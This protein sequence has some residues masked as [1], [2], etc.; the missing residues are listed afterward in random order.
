MSRFRRFP[1]PALMLA[2]SAA[3]LAGCAVG[4]DYQQPR[5]ALTPT[6]HAAAP[7]AAT[8]APA[9]ETWWNGFGD[10]ALTRVIQRAAAQNMDI[11]QA[12]ARIAQ[13]R[14]AVRA[15]NAALLPHGE[16]QGGATDVSQS[17][18]SPFGEIGKQVPGFERDYGLYE[19][20]AA[21]S[22]EIDLFGGLRRQRE[23]ARADD[24]ATL[25]QAE[26]VQVSVLAEA[27][28][29][30]LQV[31]G[32]Q[33]RLAVAQRQIG[34]Q[35]DLVA[36]LKH[37]VDDGVGSDREL[38]EAAGALEGVQAVVPPLTSA[39]EAQM[40]RLDVLMGAQP[41]TYRAEVEADAAIPAPP[42]ISTA[43]GPAGLLR[44]RPDILAAEQ[45]LIAENAQIGV[46][47]SDYYPK[48]SLGGLFGGQSLD[49][50]RIFSSEALQSQYGVSLRWRLFDFGRVDAE[51]AAARGRK[52]E[53]LA[54]YRSV[55]LNATEEV[56]DAVTDLQQQQIRIGTLRRQIDHLTLA[57]RQAEQAYEGGVVSLVEVRDLDR[58]LLAASDQLVLAQTGASRAAVSTFRALGG[59]WDAGVTQV[60]WR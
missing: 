12:R 50:H 60:A 31:R 14:A 9:I 2:A 58:D 1:L 39:L 22:W 19:L 13:S 56:E 33:A 24:R 25:G 53:A 42:A 49:S 35:R 10:P 18:L 23:S 57:R 11:A 51:V 7:A 26:A 52:A 36:L 21:A 15:A 16:V 3:A 44:R 30:Y 17:L 59:G 5:L 40:N 38:N 34:V 37:K 20:G 48:V 27:A 8:P 45:H 4:P 6:F 54:H 29:A 47:I 55:V 32:L 43:D 28:D 41:G 46:A